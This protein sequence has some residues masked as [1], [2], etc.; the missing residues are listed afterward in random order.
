MLL[1]KVHEEFHEKNTAS[2]PDYIILSVFRTYFFMIFEKFMKPCF[3]VIDI[4][5]TVWTS[6][7]VQKAYIKASG[8]NNKHVTLMKTNTH[9]T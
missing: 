6:T 7:R 9:F 4:S 2:I 8:Y 5:V 3:H 1:N